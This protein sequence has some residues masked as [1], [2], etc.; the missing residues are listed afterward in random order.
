MSIFGN[1]DVPVPEVDGIGMPLGDSNRH[2]PPRDEDE[3]AAH[4]AAALRSKQT[5]RPSAPP[6]DPKN[7]EGGDMTN[8]GE[9]L[10]DKSRA[11]LDQ[12]RASAEAA[13]DFSL[14]Y[15]EWVPWLNDHGIPVPSSGDP[16]PN[17]DWKQ[18]RALVG[19]FPSATRKAKAHYHEVQASIENLHSY[20]EQAWL[21][22]CEL[23]AQAGAQYANTQPPE[24]TNPTAP[25]GGTPTPEEGVMKTSEQIK[26]EAAELMKDWVKPV[27]TSGL[28]RWDATVWDTSRI[29][30]GKIGYI[31]ILSGKLMFSN[32]TYLEECVERGR[33]HPFDSND[34][35]DQLHVLV[36]EWLSLDPAFVALDEADAKREVSRAVYRVLRGEIAFEEVAYNPPLTPEERAA[37]LAASIQAAPKPEAKKTKSRRRGRDKGDKPKSASALPPPPVTPVVVGSPDNTVAGRPLGPMG[38]AAAK[39]IAEVWESRSS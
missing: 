25:P 6:G 19:L 11:A 4:L 1:R 18:V 5:S 24:P 22:A 7:P 38:R 28:Y 30:D 2:A 23:L 33:D 15:E 17:E 37:A 8:L 9:M 16:N 27:L 20:L 35:L 29:G 12:A 13:V 34:V 14:S 26:A 39:A 36:R 31:G 32:I 10:D 21:A 3:L